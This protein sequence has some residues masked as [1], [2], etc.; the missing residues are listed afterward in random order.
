MAKVV[1]V[2]GTGPQGLLTEQCLWDVCGNEGHM[3]SP[4]TPR[5]MRPARQTGHMPSELSARL[6]LAASPRRG[7]QS[8][9]SHAEGA[10]CPSPRPFPGLPAWRRARAGAPS[11]CTA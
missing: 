6:V 3:S 9:R 4:W 10:V 11:T 2:G 1:V 8:G 5:A 7:Q